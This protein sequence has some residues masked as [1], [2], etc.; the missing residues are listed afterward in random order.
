VLIYKEI[1]MWYE[2]QRIAQRYWIEFAQRDLMALE[3]AYLCGKQSKNEDDSLPPNVVR[4]NSK[5]ENH[6]LIHPSLA[7]PDDHP[8]Y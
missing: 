5:A 1:D 4:I 8:V 2:I 7:I 3:E 6:G